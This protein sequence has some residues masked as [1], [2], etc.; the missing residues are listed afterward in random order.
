[1]NDLFDKVIDRR[2]TGCIKYDFSLEHG[3]PEDALPMWV[4]DMDFRTAPEITQELRRVTDHGIYGY[5]GVQED[6]KA[7]VTAWYRDRFGWQADPNWMIQTPGVVFALAMSV[8]AFTKPGE[9][10]LVQ[11]PVYHPFSNMIIRNKRQL[12]NSP[13]VLKDGCYSIDFDDF[14][15]KASLPEVRL[16]LLCS[17]H[18]PVGRV[19]TPEELKTLEEICLRHDVIVVSD[20]IHSDFVWDGHTH[21]VLAGISETYHQNTVICTAPSKTFNLAGLQTSNIFI[22]DPALRKRFRETIEAVGYGLPNL[23]GLSACRAAYTG[24]ASWLEQAKRYI[25]DNICFMDRY[26]REEIPQLRMTKPEGTYLTWVDFRDLGLSE[27]Q[28][29]E[30]LLQK[31]KLWLDSGAMFGPEGEGF[32]RFNLACPRALLE[33]GLEQLKKACEKDI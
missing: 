15:R 8:L 30:L 20:E 14:E 16:F 11:R 33:Q 32:E 12:V 26:L 24:G 1:M 25:W 13:L 9:G 23:F 29:Q 7:A 18:N 21:H 27:N 6:Y 10:V 4:A 22:P 5:T 19:W 31:A 28:R 3:V 17:P 2:G